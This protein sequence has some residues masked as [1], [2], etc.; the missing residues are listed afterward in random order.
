MSLVEIK[1]LTHSFG[2][3]ILFKNAD[4][5]LNK[6][7]HAGVVGNNGAGKSTFIKICTGQ[8]V[9]DSG[10][11]SWTKGIT[12]GY[13]DQYAHIEAGLTQEGFLKSAFLDLYRLEE[14]MN[15]LYRRAAEGDMDSMRRAARYQE[16][17]E[18]SG[19]YSIDTYI[20]QVAAGLGLTGIGME[21]PVGQ[22]SGGQRA[23]VILAKLLL[24]KPDVLL[25]DEP[26][27]FLDKE[28]VAWLGGYLSELEN[29]FLVVSHDHDFLER[30]CNRICDIDNR[31]ITKYYG[32]YSEFCKKKALL[33]EDYIRQYSAQ[34]KEI[35]RTEE[36]IRK[37][38]AGRKSR[39][40]RGRQKQ[41]DRMEKIEALVLKELKPVFKFQDM[42]VTNTEYLAVKHLSVGYDFPVLPDISFSVTG[43]QKIAVTGFNGI[44]KSTL[45]KTLVG[46]IPPLGGTYAFS[47]QAEVAYFEQDLLWEDGKKTPLQVITDTFPSIEP[48]KVRKALARCGISSAHADQALETLSG[49]EQAK[50]KLCLLTLRP[51][52]FLIMDEPTNHLDIQAKEALKEA[53]QEFAGAVVLVSHEAS[54]YRE[55]V[56]RVINVEGQDWKHST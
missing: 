35:K 8:A 33:R 2:D 29:A 30:I 19:F 22:M 38:I 21:R 3:N 39:M 17:L 10:S 51:C 45:L 14:Q 44:G 42:P 5:V 37:N 40:A 56:S 1:D 48:K 28:H 7:E 16:R 36:F 53:I 4:F 25:L 41:L 9:P 52:S 46:Q 15:A 55:V 18:A 26:T 49:G 20:S 11:V 24:E 13:L 31:T 34:Q 6:G 12:A 50:V 47:G 43:G 32:T 23:K 54:F 27:N